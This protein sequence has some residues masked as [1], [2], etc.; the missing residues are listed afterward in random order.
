MNK[1]IISLT[2]CV[3]ISIDR[4]STLRVFAEGYEQLNTVND[5]DIMNNSEVNYGIFKKGDINLDGNIDIAFHIYDSYAWYSI[6]NS[7]LL[8]SIL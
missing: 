7:E 2:L 8:K 5:F 4:I 3:L 1:K 6:N